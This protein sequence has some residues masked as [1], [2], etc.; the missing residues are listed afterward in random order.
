MP[1]SQPQQTVAEDQNR[2]KVLITGRRFGKTHLGIREL[3][4]S[5][6][7]KPGSINWAVCPSYRMAKQIWWEQIKTKLHELRWIKSSNEAELTIKLKNGSTIALK[8]CDNPD[9]LRGVGLDFVIFDEFQDSPKEAWT[10]VIRPTLSDKRG[11]ALFTGTPKG[12]GSWSHELFTKALNE[13]D[14]N[15]W[16]FTTIQGGN[17]PEEE[18][19]AARRDLDEK[20]FLAEYMATFNT[21]SGTVYYNF[22]YKGNVQKLEDPETGV[23]HVGMDFNWDPFCVVIAQVQ[24]DR[25][26]I[27][28]ELHI[29]GSS[30]EDVVE[31]LTRRYPHSKVAVYPD[32][33]ARQKKTSAGGKTDYS[34]LINAGFSVRA[35]HF[36]TPVRDR[37]NA[38]NALLKNAMGQRRLLIDPKCKHTIDSLQR[39]CYKEGTTVVDKDLGIEH[40]SDAVG[41]LCDFIAP[42]KTR[43]ETIET[44]QRWGVA[45][46]RL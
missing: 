18:I 14:W 38:V 45:T 17:V 1:L 32:P 46:K 5:A 23:I 41:Y 36:H 13:K 26:H 9:S 31:E 15:A 42:V 7:T 21:Y 10:E 24:G 33:A 25:I 44:P 19:E 29:K 35:R 43:V 12:V 34:I 16:Q 37:V 4:K 3:C 28:D 8:G 30:T 40:I 39:V 27:F 22:D 6:A 11:R 2:F 20:T